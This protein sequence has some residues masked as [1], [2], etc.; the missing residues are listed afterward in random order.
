MFSR[1]RQRSPHDLFSLM[2]F[3]SSRKSIDMMKAAEVFDV[4]LRLIE[5]CVRQG[6][7][8][9]RFAPKHADQASKEI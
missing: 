6:A 5:C 9:K 8:I 2:R 3:P 7:K 1:T 4:S